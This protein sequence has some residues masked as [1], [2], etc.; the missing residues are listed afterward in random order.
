MAQNDRNELRLGQVE[1]RK[2]SKGKVANIAAQELTTYPQ[3]RND[4]SHIVCGSHDRPC[5]LHTEDETSEIVRN[6]RFAMHH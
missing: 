3:A 2:G 1:L 5:P 6:T 4:S